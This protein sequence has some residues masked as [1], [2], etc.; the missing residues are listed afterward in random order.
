MGALYDYLSAGKLLSVDEPPRQDWTLS[1]LIHDIDYSKDTKEL[2]PANTRQVLSL[3]GLEIN[4][5]VLH[6][7]LAHAPGLTNV[8][9]DNLASWS[10]FCADSLTGLISAVALV[11]PTK[12]LSDVKLSSVIKRLLKDPKFAAGTRRDEI[13]KCQQPDGLN[14]SLEIFVGICLKAMQNISHDLGL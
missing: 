7:V 2:H 13:Q 10:I 5:Q 12:K 1:G 8:Y 3:Y 11:Q 9:P 14:L 6:I 4:D